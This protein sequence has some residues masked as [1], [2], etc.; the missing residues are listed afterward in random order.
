MTRHQWATCLHRASEPTPDV[1]PD[2]FEG[3]WLCRKRFLPG[4]SSAV[5]AN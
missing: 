5:F 1:A 3:S 4:I 2:A